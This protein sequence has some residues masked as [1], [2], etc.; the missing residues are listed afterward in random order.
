MAGG[1]YYLRDGLSVGLSADAWLGSQPQVYDVSPE[2]RYVFLDSSWHY[3]PYGGLFY[4]RTFYNREFGPL[5]SIGGR[6][7]LVFP[8][9]S[10]AYLT[11]GAAYEHYFNCNKSVYTSCD[12]VYPEIGLSFVF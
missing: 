3:K 2:V 9:N 5:D 7:G 8:L 12:D 6:A 11:G 4:R 1:G 10:R